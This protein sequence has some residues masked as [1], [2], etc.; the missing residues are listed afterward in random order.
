MDI[1][2]RAVDRYGNPVVY[3]NYNGPPI[4][5]P[6]N[7]GMPKGSYPPQAAYRKP[8]TPNQQASSSPQPVQS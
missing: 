8:H 2:G 3:Q 1:H 5:D 7:L 6:Y 4:H